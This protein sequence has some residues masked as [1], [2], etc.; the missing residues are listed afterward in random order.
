[1]KPN[2]A[3]IVSALFIG[4]LSIFCTAIIWLPLALGNQTCEYSEM[5]QGIAIFEFGCVVLGLTYLVMVLI[6][7]IK[8]R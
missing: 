6:H 5:N 1:M 3:Y 2:K 7:A 4:L 8:A